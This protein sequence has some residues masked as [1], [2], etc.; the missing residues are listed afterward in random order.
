VVKQEE[1]RLSGAWIG[2]QL[3]EEE[4]LAGDRVHRVC[5]H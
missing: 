5:R 1:A 3:H 2:G 4:V